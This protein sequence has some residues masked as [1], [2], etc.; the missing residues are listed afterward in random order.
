[1][2]VSVAGERLDL[3]GRPG[4]PRNVVVVAAR[5]AAAAARAYTATCRYLGG[6][7]RVDIPIVRNWL[8]DCIADLACPTKQ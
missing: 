4:R 6:Y 1:V 5:D 2:P 8:S 7:Q 3:G